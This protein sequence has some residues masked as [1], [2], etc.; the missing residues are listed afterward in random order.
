MS[1]PRSQNY[2]IQETPYSIFL[3]IRKSLNQSPIN[4]VIISE[5]KAE[6]TK[7]TDNDFLKKTAEFER[8]R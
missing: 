3:T 8:I 5:I 1:D 6:V 2:A 4:Q 7:H